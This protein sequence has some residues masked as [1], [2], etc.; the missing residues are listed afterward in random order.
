LAPLKVFAGNALSPTENTPLPPTE[1]V[2]SAC[3]G[4]ESTDAVLK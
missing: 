2:G 4:G 1:L 3:S